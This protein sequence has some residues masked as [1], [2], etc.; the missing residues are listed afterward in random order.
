MLSEKYIAKLNRETKCGCK[1][2]STAQN[3]L[4]FSSIVKIWSPRPSSSELSLSSFIRKTTPTLSRVFSYVGLI[5]IVD[6]VESCMMADSLSVIARISASVRTLTSE[7]VSE[8]WYSLTD[9][10]LRRDSISPD[11]TIEGTN[12]LESL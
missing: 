8:E 4:S 10:L 7:S 6:S 5:I 9:D 1:N 11:E 2:N 12:S 3:E